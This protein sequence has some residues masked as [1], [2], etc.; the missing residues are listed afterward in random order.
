[1]LNKTGDCLQVKSPTRSAMLAIPFCNECGKH[2]VH[3]EIVLAANLGETCQ[4]ATN[5]PPT[6]NHF[7]GIP[8]QPTSTRQGPAAL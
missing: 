5:P 3:E 8:A 6:T 2:T 4:S 1:M 7:L